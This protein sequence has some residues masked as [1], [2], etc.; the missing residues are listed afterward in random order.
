MPYD[1]STTLWSNAD[2]NFFSDKELRPRHQEGP[3]C[4]ST[5]LAVLTGADPESFQGI[6][7]TQDPISWSEELHKF[8][9]KLAYCPIDVRKLKFYMDELIRLD[10]LFLLC[11][12]SPTDDSILMDPDSSGWVCGSHVVVLHRDQILDS[13]IGIPAPATQHNC[14]E[15]YTKRI[16]RVV[17]VDH[18]KGV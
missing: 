10:D 18:P 14:M 7:N 17:P 16:F 13:L 4:V 15:H 3:H 6:V 5:A 12:Y 11:Y 8:G 9:M 2:E 1:M